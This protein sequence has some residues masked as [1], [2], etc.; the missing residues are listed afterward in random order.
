VLTNVK[1]NWSKI[2]ETSAELLAPATGFFGRQKETAEVYQLLLDRKLAGTTTQP[3]GLLNIHGAPGIGK[4]ETC[5]A[6]LRQ[7]LSNNPGEMVFYTELD[8]ARDGLYFSTRLLETLGLAQTFSQEN[9]FTFLKSHPGVLYLD[10]LD[11]LLE[12]QAT[13][14]LVARLAAIPGLCVLA[15]SREPLPEPARPIP[16][17]A[18][19]PV[20]AAGLFRQEWPSNGAASQLL[21]EQE[22]RD[23]LESDLDGHPL[24]IVLAAAQGNCYESL[25]ALRQSWQENILQETGGL[26]HRNNPHSLE[27]AISH[28]LKVVIRE[29]PEAVILWSVLGLF[30]EGLGLTASHEVVRGQTVKEMQDLLI[31]LSIARPTGSGLLKVPAPVRQFILD[32]IQAGL[33]GIPSSP[34]TVS[35]NPLASLRRF[36]QT[37]DNKDDPE[38][39]E[40]LLFKLVYQYYLQRARQLE[41]IIKN[42]ADAINLNNLL[43]DFPNLHYFSY[44]AAARGRKWVK[45]LAVLNQYLLRAYQWR[46]LTG[47]NIQQIILD[48]QERQYHDF[49]LATA[50]RSLGDTEETL[51]RAEEAFSCYRRAITLYQKKHANFGLANTYLSLAG[52]EERHGRVDEALEDYKR[53][54]E[55]YKQ[56]RNKKDLANAYRLLGSL[57]GEHERVEE[58][59]EHYRQAIKLYQARHD[60]LGLA[61]SQQS[62]GDLKHGLGQVDEALLHYQQ[63]I[64]LFKK[65]HHKP[66]LA[67]ANQ[68]LGDLEMSRD[69]I[70]GAQKFYLEAR[71]LFAAEQDNLG[72]AHA[73]SALARVAAALGNL[74]SSA[75]YLH[76]ARQAA[77]ECAE[78]G[79]IE[80][81][82]STAS[83]LGLGNGNGPEK[84]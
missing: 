73:C 77:T 54:I 64:E 24:A 44:Y 83:Q 21:D 9:M 16:L 33:P 56:E 62:L 60:Y 36:F 8:E 66:G 47:H 29:L 48:L 22:L 40:D 13:A 71:S 14:E 20:D 5:K 19:D 61:N 63:A 12:D 17:T 49:G 30:P 57:E 28:S 51:G 2:L 76:E 72:A 46:I 26:H 67:S 84:A 11:N 1:D 18:L 69:N 39:N 50:Y 37:K 59:Y 74:E 27:N 6:A 55:L 32:Q 3:P 43:D 70:A 35:N 15:S 42:D 68:S 45:E 58:A 53:A 81:V 25:T 65:A 52:L 34:A 7:Y 23:F 75:S 31:R 82:E 38:F 10:G 78:P 80:Q 41:T 4:T 79:I